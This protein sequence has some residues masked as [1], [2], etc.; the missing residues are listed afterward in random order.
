[1]RQPALWRAHQKLCKIFGDIVHLSVFGQHLV[2]LGSQRVIFDI[3]EK[4][5]AGTSDRQQ[6]PLIELSGQGFNFAFFPYD[7]WW[8][9]HR[10]IF[11][12]CIPTIVPNEQLLVQQQY[13]TLFLK[14]LLHNPADFCDH[15]R[16][17]FSATIV[18]IVYGVE[19]ADDNDPNVDLMVRLL[20]GLQAFNSP[21][22]LVQYFP[23][24]Q[25]V[26]LWVPILGSQL[27]MLA[28]WRAAADEVKQEHGR[29][30]TSVLARILRGLEEETDVNMAEEHL[31]A[32]NTCV[33]A[34][35]GASDTT[36]STT[37]AFFLAMSLNSDVQKRAQAELDVVIGPHR[38]PDQADRAS[39]PYVSA[40]LKESLRWHN[41]APFGVP[42]CNAEDIE[43][44]MHD[45]EVYPEPD[46]F[47]PDRFMR[48]G[49]LN[50]DVRDPE[51][52][53]FGYGRRKCPGKAFAED[54]MFAIIAMTLHVFDITPP[55]DETGK[56]IV[57]TPSVEGSF[58][59]YLEDCRCS[60]KPRSAQA[61]ALILG[62]AVESSDGLAERKRRKTQDRN[63]FMNPPNE[64][65]RGRGSRRLALRRDLGGGGES[66][67]NVS[68][69]FAREGGWLGVRARKGLTAGPWALDFDADEGGS[70]EDTTGKRW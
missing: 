13:A 67:S 46:R 37:Q 19:V 61:E 41:V 54:A 59:T 55:L 36:F 45:P 68:F 62:A 10:R 48:D 16:Y 40:V 32:K 43:A 65:D 22:I 31:I 53:V 58:M 7:Q 12:Q 56:P 47:L 30:N 63:A 25:H 39:L 18:K 15:I 69:R 57:I 52:F 50:P 3:L 1:M 20:E 21:R 27:R 33:T 14:K 5:S 23:I 6:H 44:C 60:I 2:V 38:L 70:P 64:L 49:K 11:S 24:L 66:A 35:E 28:G 8:R 4:Q 34:F 42:H 51:D 17:V 26:P 9:R 29:Q